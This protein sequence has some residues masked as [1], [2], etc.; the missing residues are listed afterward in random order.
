MRKTILSLVAIAISSASL[1]A[2]IPNNGFENWTTVGAYSVPNSWGT[3]NNTT[4]LAGVYT[5]TVGTP[6]SC[7]KWYCSEWSFRFNHDATKV[8]FCL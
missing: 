7:G 8:R 6:G 4:T 1:F 5:A 2:Q 3:L